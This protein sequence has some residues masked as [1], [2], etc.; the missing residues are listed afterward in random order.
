MFRDFFIPE[1]LTENSLLALEIT[2]LSQYHTGSEMKRGC[3]IGIPVYLNSVHL[4]IY[5][6]NTEIKLRCF[7]SA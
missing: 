4:L 7:E 5:L 6:H 3:L 1:F 2:R